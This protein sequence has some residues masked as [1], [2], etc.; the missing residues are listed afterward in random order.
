MYCWKCGAKIPDGSS[1]CPDCGYDERASNEYAS[2]PV[3]AYTPKRKHASKEEKVVEPAP[4]AVEQKKGIG[5]KISSL[6]K[7]K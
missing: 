1:A 6:F 5:D 4:E 7:R 2:K 3:S